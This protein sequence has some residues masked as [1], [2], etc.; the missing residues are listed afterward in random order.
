MLIVDQS[1]TWTYLGVNERSVP[2][3]DIGVFPSSSSWQSHI[4]IDSDRFSVSM[5]D[6]DVAV[7]SEHVSESSRYEGGRI[8]SDEKGRVVFGEGRLV[9]S[10][11]GQT[12]GWRVVSQAITSG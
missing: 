12:T 2:S 6:L 1:G 7:L 5:V 10:N 11:G 8:I 4:E 3:I 9:S